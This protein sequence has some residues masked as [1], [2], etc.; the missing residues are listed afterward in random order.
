V[1]EVYCT[2]SKTLLLV[3]D[4]LLWKWRE[5]WMLEERSADRRWTA[6]LPLC[7]RVVRYLPTGE[8]V[9]ASE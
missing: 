6:F 8:K 2:C 9:L 7:G 1:C 5:D 4:F 3:Y